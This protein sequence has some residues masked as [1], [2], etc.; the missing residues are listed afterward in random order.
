VSGFYE[1]RIFRLVAQCLA[2]LSD[3]HLYYCFTYTNIGPQSLEQLLFGHQPICV[4]YQVPQ[5]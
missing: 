5:H 4:F 3:T 2:D 1:L